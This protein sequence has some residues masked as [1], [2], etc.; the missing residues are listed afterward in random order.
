MSSATPSHRTPSVPDDRST[1]STW[2][3]R[4]AT[5]IR[6]TAFW[7]AT[8]LPL[9][10]VAVIAAGPAGEYPAA[11]AV[12]VALNVVCAVVGHDHAPGR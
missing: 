9:L 3:D 4:F 2:I 6:A 11:F 8:V 10:L 1:V 5:G 7:T 12:A